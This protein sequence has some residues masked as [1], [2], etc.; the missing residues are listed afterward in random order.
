MRVPSPGH[1][2]GLRGF[3]VGVL[4]TLVVIGVGAIAVASGAKLW[5]A[6]PPATTQPPVTAP[7]VTAPP[8]AKPGQ[9]YIV[10]VASKP[11]FNTA[12]RIAAQLRQ[13]GFRKVGV[14]R[15]SE[16]GAQV[17]NSPGLK[18]DLYVTFVGPWEL[19]EQGYAEAKAA[20]RQVP[21]SADFR[22]SFVRPISPG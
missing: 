12:A 11:D 16:Y 9:S 4:V 15:S 21:D 14:L 10:Q 19:T 17:L 2:P 1:R 13:Q 20:L 22:G 5:T 8:V 6:R 7:P 18:P 3:Q